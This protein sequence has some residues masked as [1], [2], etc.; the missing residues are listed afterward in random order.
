MGEILIL[1]KKV[2]V[3]DETGVGLT[4]H[5][6]NYEHEGRTK[7]FYYLDPSE[8]GTLSGFVLI[9]RSFWGRTSRMYLPLPAHVLF[10]IRKWLPHYLPDHNEDCY[11][12]VNDVFEIERHPKEEGYKFWG[13]APPFTRARPGDA[14]FFLDL[15]D[16][17]FRHAS[18]YLGDNLCI[19]VNGKNGAVGVANVR[20]LKRDYGAKDVCLMRMIDGGG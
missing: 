3:S 7:S 4:T 18:I 6:L 9:R 12:F 17:G 20:D 10:G 16:N 13:I 1:D 19:S 5:P 11:D 8:I 2:R 14:V 15:Q